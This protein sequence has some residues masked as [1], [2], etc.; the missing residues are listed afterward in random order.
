MSSCDIN[1][2]GDRGGAAAMSVQGGARVQED[3]GGAGGT[4]DRGGTGGKA[5]PNG[6]KVVEGR[7]TV[8]GPEVHGAGRVTL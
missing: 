5:E 3:R 1:G 7:S 2:S 8:E 6:A 4:E